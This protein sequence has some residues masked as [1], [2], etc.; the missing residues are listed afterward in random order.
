[1]KEQHDE[2]E[3]DITEI[4]RNAIRKGPSCEEEL[5]AL[6]NKFADLRK[7]PAIFY[8]DFDK[9][10]MVECEYPESFPWKRDDQS[11]YEY[12]FGIS[13]FLA[14]IR[15]NTKFF[16]ETCHPRDYP[17][18]SEI[19]ISRPE[20][21]TVVYGLQFPTSTYRSVFVSSGSIGDTPRAGYLSIRWIRDDERENPFLDIGCYGPSDITDLVRDERTVSKA[22]YA[23]GTQL[24]VV[25]GQ[26]AIEKRL[27]EKNRGLEIYL[28]AAGVVGW[29]PSEEVKLKVFQDLRRK[30][31]F[32]EGNTMFWEWVYHMGLHTCGKRGVGSFIRRKLVEAIEEGGRV[33]DDTTGLQEILNYKD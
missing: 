25:L 6:N 3:R 28:A 18:E 33:A 21:P 7:S 29:T 23:K 19:I 32:E 26:E 17:P 31:R 30:G 2:Q 1:M 22:T 14:S 11:S 5:T 13:S 15:E 12:G 16:I 4:V 20:I 27:L 8:Q 10:M 24:C 9:P